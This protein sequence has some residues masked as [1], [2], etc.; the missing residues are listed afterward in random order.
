[1]N[2]LKLAVGLWLAGF[3]AGAGTLYT[4]GPWLGQVMLRTGGQLVQLDGDA[5]LTTAA[6]VQAVVAAAADEIV[7]E[8]VSALL[9]KRG[10]R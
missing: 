4:A 3:V 2:R 9:G 8:R 6:D 7:T 10:M 5:P 1:M